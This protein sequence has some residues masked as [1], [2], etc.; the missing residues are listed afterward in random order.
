MTAS[1]HVSQDILI[2]LAIAAVIVPLFGRLRVS[3]VLGFLGA[4][5]ILGPFGLGSLA[6][7]L[8]VIAD[9]TFSDLPA[10]ERLGEF[11]VAFLLFIIGLELSWDRLLRIRKLVFGLGPA[12]VI[13]SGAA[14]ALIAWVLGALPRSAFVFGAALALSSTA[15][16]LPA[17]AER[18]RLNS[19]AGRA[20][21]A[22]LLFQDLAVAPLLFMVTLLA[23]RP[24]GSNGFAA[25]TALATA[26]AALVVL[27][28]AGRLVLRP[29]FQ[30]VAQTKSTELFVAACLLVVI[31]AASITAAAGQ[32]MA[33]GT[34]IAGLLLAETEFRR[35]VEVTV[36]PF[37]GLLLGL[38]FI[39]VGARLD[40]SQVVA[41]PGLFLGLAFGLMVVKILVLV[42]LARFAGL[43]RAV[44]N[45]LALI[46]APAG[47]FAL[48]LIGAAIAERVVPAATGATA[49]LAATLSM[50]AIPFLVRAS[51][52][53]G[54]PASDEAE[55]LALMPQVADESGRVIIVGYGRVGELVGQMLSHHEIP[56]LA[57]DGDAEL[58]ARERQHGTH[59]FYGDATRLDLLR[60]SGIA[61]ARALVVTM[62][63]PAAV[64][65]V[66]AAARAERPD[67]TIVARA[68]DAA[69]AAKLYDLDVTDAVPET[70]EASLQLSEA[71][72]IDIGLP[73]GLVIASIH[74]KRDQYRDML[75]TPAREGR[76]RLAIRNARQTEES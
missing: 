4:G 59:I 67:L 37:Q 15:I 52:G 5:V 16:V 39:S 53:I 55:A 48:V 35:Q 9:L 66:I 50:F 73:M 34:F 58:V 36:Q 22:I 20:S 69:H 13:A 24:G 49:M 74:E 33:L 7:R 14:V 76:E 28:F 8:P 12:Q 1:P 44:A 3:P 56:F 57:I 43:G 30:L 31:G 51:E 32:S 75:Q 62:D 45:Q 29:L 60:L 64:E 2:F 23:A 47:E 11:G 10:I 17:L 6:G 63:A 70:I 65:A 19:A 61:T 25:I 42:P 68:R 46:L 54:P 71:L 40:L 26:L 38:F 27:V 18:K 72:L 41:R 21:F